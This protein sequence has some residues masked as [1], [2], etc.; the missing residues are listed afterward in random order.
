MVDGEHEWEVELKMDLNS[1]GNW[2]KVK[3]FLKDNFR[4]IEQ[5][6]CE[7]DNVKSYLAQLD[8]LQYRL[9]KQNGRIYDQFYE[10]LN[11]LGIVQLCI[12]FMNK[13]PSDYFKQP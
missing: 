2:E 1:L 12:N 8:N 5:S 9:H 11:K 10:L 7:T 4:E 3:N 6:N 13:M